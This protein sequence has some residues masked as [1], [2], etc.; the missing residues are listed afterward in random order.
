MLK[1]IS[2]R[3][4][5]HWSLPRPYNF[6]PSP[7]VLSLLKTGT[8]RTRRYR[9]SAYHPKLLEKHEQEK[10]GVLLV[11]SKVLYIHHEMKNNCERKIQ[12]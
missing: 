1:S 6:V 5:F 12:G 8:S 10:R 2:K 7:S 9:R 3:L 11:L 4:H